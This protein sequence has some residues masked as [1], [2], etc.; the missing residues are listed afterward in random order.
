MDYFKKYITYKTKYLQ[1]K[2]QLGGN[3][4]ADYYLPCDITHYTKKLTYSDNTA[5]KLRENDLSIQPSIKKTSANTGRSG[6]NQDPYIELY[7][8]EEYYD[9]FINK[10]DIIK[11]RICN[12]DVCIYQYKRASVERPNQIFKKGDRIPVLFNY[13]KISGDVIEE[14]YLDLPDELKNNNIFSLKIDNHSEYEQSKGG[15]FISAPDNTIF[16]VSGVNPTILEKLNNLS[17]KKV[18]LECSFK[19]NGFRHMDELMCFMPYGR[20]Q[21]KIWFYDELNIT[22]FTNLN[23]FNTKTT[24][25][26]QDW[27]R[28]LNCERMRNLDKISMALFGSEYSMNIEEFVFF[29]FYSYKPSIF[30]RVWIEYKDSCICLFNRLNNQPNNMQKLQAEKLKLKSCINNREPMIFDIKV[31]E[32]NENIPEGG[33]HCLI[34]Q[35]FQ[36][37][38]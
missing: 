20:N 34:K 26:K 29:D 24:E 12:S 23:N 21:Y 11:T 22:S 31:A 19:A 33:I 28:I 15:N 13:M 6:Y 5:N 30:N 10:L 37:I 2:K 8:G 17:C 18:E 4:P 9:L 16:Y 36:K 14:E 27:L 7:N 32:S 1:L 25:Q 38:E 35:Q 3:I